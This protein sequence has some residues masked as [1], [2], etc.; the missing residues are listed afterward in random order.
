MNL[1]TLSRAFLYGCAA[2]YFIKMRN[3]ED[4]KIGSGI[5]EKKKIIFVDGIRDFKYKY[6]IFRYLGFLALFGAYK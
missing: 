3:Y 2:Y 5:S 1:I 6:Q 4:V